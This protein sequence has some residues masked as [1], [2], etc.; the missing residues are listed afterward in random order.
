MTQKDIK[1][2]VGY[3]ARSNMVAFHEIQCLAHVELARKHCECLRV[4]V[5]SN[6]TDKQIWNALLDTRKA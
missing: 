5:F 3:F 4:G 2:W 6:V 1:R